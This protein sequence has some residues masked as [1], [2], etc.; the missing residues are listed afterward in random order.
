MSSPAGI[1]VDPLSVTSV[2]LKLYF[3][4]T[5]LATATG[6]IVYH[7]SKYYLVTNWHVLSGRDPN[8]EK[9]L[10]KTAGIPNEVRI[11]HHLKVRLGDWRFHGETL[12]NEDGSRR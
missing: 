9:P 6:I 10:S 5:Q 7:A 11:A 1:S 12:I 4:E 3:D 2:Y 8:T